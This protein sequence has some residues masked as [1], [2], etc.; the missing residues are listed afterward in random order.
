MIKEAVIK[1]AFSLLGIM[2]LT[3][4]VLLGGGIEKGYAAETKKGKDSE[5]CKSVDEFLASDAYEAKVF[6]DKGYKEFVIK[7]PEEFVKKA[8]LKKPDPK[9][10]AKSVIIRVPLEESNDEKVYQYNKDSRDGKNNREGEVTTQDLDLKPDYV[11]VTDTSYAC[12][13]EEIQRVSGSKGTLTLTVS[14]KVAATFSANVSVSA[15]IVSA[16]V[17]FNVTSEYTVTD[18]NTVD[19]NGRFTELVAYPYYRIKYFDVYDEATFGSDN[20]LGSGEAWKPIG[21]CFAVFD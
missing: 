9:L 19:T 20:Y 15:E 7:N 2:T 17:G 14:E 21:V 6:K 4:S 13:V 3:F 1:K 10:K 11:T 16:G 12:G 8:G 18:S 5:N